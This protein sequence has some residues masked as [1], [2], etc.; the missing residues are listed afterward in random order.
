MLK[1][2][3]YKNVVGVNIYFVILTNYDECNEKVHK[4]TYFFKILVGTIRFPIAIH[5]KLLTEY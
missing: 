2:V 1:L 5:C 4:V 3:L